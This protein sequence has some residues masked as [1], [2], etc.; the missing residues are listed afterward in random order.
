[1]FGVLAVLLLG[2]TVTG[3][4]LQRAVLRARLDRDI[5]AAHDQELAEVRS[6]A[7]GR[8]PE[9]GEPFGADAAAIFDTFLQR[10]VPDDDEV[11]VTIVG[12]RPYRSSLADVRLD[13]DAELVERWASLEAGD[14]GW[15]ASDAGPVR[16][17]ASP[18]EAGGER[19]GTFAVATFVTEDRAE[20]DDTLRVE[21]AISLV[22]VAL[23]LAIAWSVA[24]RLLRPVRDLTANARDLDERDLSARIPEAGNDEIAELARTYNAMLDRLQAGF[25]TQRRFVDDA[26]HELRTPITIISGHLELMGDDPDDRRETVA[27]VTDELDRMSRMVDDLLVLAKAEQ[28]RFIEPEPLD[29]AA[30]STGLL[31][32]AR[33]LGDRRWVLDEHA[34]ATVVADGQRLVQATLNLLRNAVEH[35]AVGGTIAIGTRCAD[36]QLQIW[37]RDD[38]PGIDLDE[39]DRLFER[40][41]RGAGGRGRSE[42]AGLGLAIVRAIAESHGGTVALQSTPG[43]GATFTITVPVTRSEPWP[44]S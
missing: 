32:R 43:Q 9:T 11:Y 4:V 8:N 18:L 21:A 22:V 23:G 34:D 12:G 7:T 37:V 1:V 20:I 30:F 40:F 28:P 44:A 6:L 29:L 25:E 41:A 17:L 27:L 13:Q 19:V 42:G 2:A 10:N 38:G 26:G 33:L 39:Q 35:T 5:E 31:E 24:G 3:I 16:W 14:R 15:A 36:D